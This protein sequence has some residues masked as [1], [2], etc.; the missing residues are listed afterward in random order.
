MVLDWWSMLLSKKKSLMEMYVH[1][2]CVTRPFLSL[3]RVW[4]ARLS[5]LL[6]KKEGSL[7][8]CRKQI[9]SVE[10]HA[11]PRKA[12]LK[13]SKVISPCVARQRIFSKCPPLDCKIKSLYNILAS[14]S[15]LT[16]PPVQYSIYVE[17]RLSWLRRHSQ[18]TAQLAFVTCSIVSL[19]ICISFIPGHLTAKISITL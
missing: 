2:C 10:A 18:E 4:L 17:N 12:L 1:G 8:R 19:K 9:W 3:R 13:E 11:V 14:F 15:N 5:W 6:H 7:H 16:N